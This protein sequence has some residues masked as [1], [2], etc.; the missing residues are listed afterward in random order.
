M[1]QKQFFKSDLKKRAFTRNLVIDKYMG[2]KQFVK[3]DL[4]KTPFPRIFFKKMYI[5]PFINQ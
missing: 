1:A 5:G 3:V 4:Q 2:K